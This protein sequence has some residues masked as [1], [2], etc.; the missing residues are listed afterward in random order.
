MIRPAER[1]DLDRIVAAVVRLNE[2]GH[3][4]DPRYQLV[5]DG[6]AR[7]RALFA[8]RWFGQFL[9]FPA[10][11]VD[12]RGDELAGLVSALVQPAH[13]LLVQPATMCV[14]NLW[15][16]PAYR[17]HGVARA[18]VTEMRRRATAAGYARHV[19]GTLANDAQAVGFWQSVGYEPLTVL[20]EAT[21]R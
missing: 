12:E 8:D 15:V 2:N 5:D 20:L 11:L 1:R 21:A 6:A 18:L 10:C 13:E 14:D 9:P 19:V 7:L 17:R 16:E 3:A 4:A